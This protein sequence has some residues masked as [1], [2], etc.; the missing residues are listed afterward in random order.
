M[1]RYGDLKNPK[2][3]QICATPIFRTN[4][5]HILVATRPKLVQQDV[6][7]NGRQR[8]NLWNSVMSG[9]LA[10]TKAHHL[11]FFRRCVIDIP[12]MLTLGQDLLI[13]V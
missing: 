10:S 8:T 12:E 9:I 4:E 7:C 1:R 11:Y 5:T 3:H 2:S 13:T 6:Q